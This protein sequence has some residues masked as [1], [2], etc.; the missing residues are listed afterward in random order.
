MLLHDEGSSNK[1]AKDVQ[2][3]LFFSSLLNTYL[4]FDNFFQLHEHY[5]Y[6]YFNMDEKIIY[7]A[8]G[9][10]TLTLVHKF[11]QTILQTNYIIMLMALGLFAISI[12]ADGILAPL[13]IIYSILIMLFATSLYLYFF[14]SNRTF[15]IEYLVVF[16]MVV[17]WDVAFVILISDVKNPEYIFKEGAKWLGI[18]SWCSYYVHTSYELV[19]R[20][21][22]QIKNT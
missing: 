15:L 17:V 18:S 22:V 2:W 12:A 9:V 6:M 3:F 8:L 11:K 13:E 5:F 4:L 21:N 16:M 10:A 19:S 14:T 1:Q 20:A 7:L